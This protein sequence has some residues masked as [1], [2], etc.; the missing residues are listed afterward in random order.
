MHRRGPE[1]PH[2]RGAP[3]GSAAALSRPSSTPPGCDVRG[4]PGAPGAPPP[5]TLQPP[6]PGPHTT[7]PAP[8][9]RTPDRRPPA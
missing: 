5:T 1:A 7:R 6:R 4:R 9:T 8:P 2:A 3:P